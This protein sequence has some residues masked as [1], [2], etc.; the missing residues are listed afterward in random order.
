MD[1][2]AIDTAA[3][4][5]AACVLDAGSGRE[6]GRAVAD[7]GKGHAEA[8]MGIL[9][10]ALERSGRAYA[11]I[12]AI[13]VAVGPGSFTGVRIGVATARGLALALQIPSAGVTT[14][15][16]LAAEARDAVPGRNVLAALD[17]GRGEIFAALF[18]PDGAEIVAPHATVAARAAALA[19]ANDAVLAGSGAGLVA[20]A[21]IADAAVAGSGRTAD[22]ATYARLAVAAGFSGPRPKPLYL[23]GADARPQDR[24]ALPRRAAP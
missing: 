12:G 17:G 23:R 9:A 24:F 20:A 15:A 6:R 21:G 18:G 3:S 16:A 11:D 19:I 22:I 14:L 8:L 1:V 2:L 13:A 10:A 5:C 4:L 7:I